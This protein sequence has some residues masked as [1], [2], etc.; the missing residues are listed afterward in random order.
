LGAYINGPT[1]ARNRNT[2]RAYLLLHAM[3]GPNVL[4]FGTTLCRDWNTA[5][6]KLIYA[7]VYAGLLAFHHRD[8]YSLDMLL[9]GTSGKDDPMVFVSIYE[10]GCR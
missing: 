4:T 7:A 1:T 9:R 6:I 2:G 8:I 3:H 5:G 10:G